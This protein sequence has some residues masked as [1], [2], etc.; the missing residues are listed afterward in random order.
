MP[1]VPTTEELTVTLPGKLADLIR[2][3]VATGNYA[4]P[5]D[6]IS[7]AV[8]NDIAYDIAPAKPEDSLE[9]W[10]RAEIPRRCAQADT[11]PEEM[12]TVEDMRQAIQDEI[13]ALRTEP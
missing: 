4:S 9:E 11:H 12:L 5:V 3:Q 7:S 8:S 13:A 1:T 10:L 2:S 6:Y